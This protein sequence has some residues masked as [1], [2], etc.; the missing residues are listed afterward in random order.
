VAP[1]PGETNGPGNGS[2]NTFINREDW[3]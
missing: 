2:G 1:P 3:S